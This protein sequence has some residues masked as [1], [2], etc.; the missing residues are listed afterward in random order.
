M[1]FWPEIRY[2]PVGAAEALKVIRNLTVYTPSWRV[3]KAS[4]SYSTLK[5]VTLKL[6]M[7]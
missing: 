1:T 7:S 3:N 4:W 5:R 2:R 6:V